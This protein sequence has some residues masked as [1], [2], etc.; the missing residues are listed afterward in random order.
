M[1]SASPLKG[2]TVR[3]K[4][5]ELVR[6]ARPTPIE[7][8]PLSDIDDQDGVRFHISNIHFYRKRPTVVG[9]GNDDPAKVIKAALAETLVYYYPFAGRLREEAG[10][11]LVVDCTG[12]GVL[13]AEADA[14]VTLD[15]FG[16]ELQ[17]PFRGLDELLFN[18]PDNCG[19][20]YSPLLFIQVTRLRCGGFVLTYILNHTMADGA[21]MVQFMSAVAEIA[22]GASAPSVTPVWM[23]HLLRA[24][25][26]PRITCAHP[27]YDPIPDTSKPILLPLEHMVC[28]SFFFSQAEI[29]ALRSSLPPH[30]RSKC[31]NFE[32]LSACLWRC[33][34]AALQLEPDQQVR[35]L[36]IINA[37]SKFKP[38]PRGYY[39]NVLATPAAVTTARKLVNNP[40]AYA[41]ELVMKAKSEVTEEYMQSNADLV[42][43]RGRPSVNLATAYM[44]SDLTRSGFDEVDFGWGKPIFAGPAIS[45]NPVVGVIGFYI[46]KKNSKG[47]NG[48]VVPVCLP[49]FAMQRFI[50][51]IEMILSKVESEGDEGDNDFSLN[52]RSAL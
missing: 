10:R 51:Q 35:L 5:H 29:S 18:V 26:P 42:V 8:K 49:E 13:F 38:F 48:M 50:D 44:V 12:E 1:G 17:P 16:E 30:L 3:R 37:R 2:F 21:G 40:L 36:C 34:T 28:R 23:R 45:M 9:G 20:L 46:P 15:D 19:I 32:I 52:L 6:P 27:E 11:K 31:S 14:D 4:N 24:R 43:L 7:T 25:D 39:G 33:R 22:R 47:V 41:A